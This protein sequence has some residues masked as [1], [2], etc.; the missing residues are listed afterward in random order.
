MAEN[1]RVRLEV[2]N[3]LYV[4]YEESNRDSAMFYTD[5]GL[6]IS[7]KINQPLWTASLL[8]NKAYLF[9]KKGN[10]SLS[11][12]L[13]N[14]SMTIAKDEKNEKNVY[15][16]EST[17]AGRDSHKWRLIIIGNG[18]HQF[19]NTYRQ[20]GNYEKAIASFKE[21]IR[22]AEENKMEDGVVNPNMN[23]GSIYFDLNKLDSAMLYTR[24]AIR[25]SNSS[26]YK[27]YQGQ[28]LLVIG[29]IFL[30]RINLIQQNITIGNH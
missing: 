7:K 24:N 25:F 20:A 18:Y 3:R 26:G 27:T 14:E 4:H 8:Q 9:Q 6:A 12:K 29:N 15:V 16:R 10:L 1:D 30:S 2:T 5:M 17:S 28:M 19:G 21:V 13:I 22:I 11:F 23:I